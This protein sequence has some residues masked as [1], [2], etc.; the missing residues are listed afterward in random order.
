[1]RERAA[2]FGRTLE[3]GVNAFVVTGPDVE[4]ARARA[5]RMYADA[6]AADP[7][8]GPIRASGLE[9]GLVGPPDLVADRVAAL[10]G[11][12]IDLV[13]CRFWPETAELEAGAAGLELAGALRPRVP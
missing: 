12:G 2:R 8:F 6:V 9:V 3:F 4:S 10:E 1:M 5:E 11:I 13:L 7:R